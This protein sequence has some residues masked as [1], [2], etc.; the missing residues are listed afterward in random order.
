MRWT[1]DTKWE[2]GKLSF[3]HG[4]SKFKFAKKAGKQDAFWKSNMNSRI[5]KKKKNRKNRQTNFRKKLQKIYLSNQLIGWME[6]WDSS[7]IRKAFRLAIQNTK[8]SS[9]EWKNGCNNNTKFI[10]PPVKRIKCQWSSPRFPN[11][12]FNSKVD[13]VDFFAFTMSLTKS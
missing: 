3:I 10:E 7:K 9:T 8:K 12:L 5:K 11:Y 13:E 2:N 4:V 6:R 1:T